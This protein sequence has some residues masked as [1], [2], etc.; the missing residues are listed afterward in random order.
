MKGNEKNEKNKMHEYLDDVRFVNFEIVKKI[1]EWK[2]SHEISECPV[3]IVDNGNYL[4]KMINDNA[5]ILKNLNEKRALFL[6][7][8]NPFF[9]SCDG[10]KTSM[11]HT[12]QQDIEECMEVMAQEKAEELRFMIDPPKYVSKAPY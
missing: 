8:P 7:P 3:F 4:I 10:N 1:N 5:N 6:S 11:S 9:L 2:K 12:Q